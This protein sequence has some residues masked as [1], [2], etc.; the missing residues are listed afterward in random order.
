MFRTSQKY[1]EREFGAV[2]STAK[3]MAQQ[4]KL[5]ADTQE[6]SQSVDNMITRV[7]GLKRKVMN[8]HALSRCFIN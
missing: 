1:I 8:V 3:E 4:S 6:L 2:Q 7:E 5:T